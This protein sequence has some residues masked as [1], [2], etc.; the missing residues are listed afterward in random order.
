VIDLLKPR[1]PICDWPLAKS[2]EKGC[3][4]GDCSY[5][6]DDPAEQRRIKERRDSLKTAD[7]EGSK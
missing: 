3:I 5:R 6:P 7:R 2:Q 4:A 1:C